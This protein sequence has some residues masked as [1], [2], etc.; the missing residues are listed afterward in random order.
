MTRF[1]ERKRNVRRAYRNYENGNADAEKVK[2][3]LE[4][5]IHTTWQHYGTR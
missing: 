3:E 1:E 2:R 4:L 5:L